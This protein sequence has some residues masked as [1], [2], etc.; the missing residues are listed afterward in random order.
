VSH[1]AG[2]TWEAPLISDRAFRGHARTN[3]V[4]PPGNGDFHEPG[5][6]WLEP[7][8]TM[9]LMNSWRSYDQ[10]VLTS[11]DLVRFT[12]LVPRPVLRHS[13]TQNAVL[14]LHGRYVVYRRMKRR[15]KDPATLALL[16]PRVTP[17][18]REIGLAVG[19]APR[20]V[21]GAPAF[22]AG[23]RAA[24]TIL[25]YDSLDG[26]QDDLYNPATNIYGDMV[27][28]FPS[29]FAHTRG[30]MRG[31]L[32]ARIAVSE[33]GVKF[34]YPGRSR[35]PWLPNVPSE[36]SI[37]VT[38]SSIHPVDASMALAP[39]PVVV[40]GDPL[41]RVIAI[42]Y[43][44]GAKEH[45]ELTGGVKRAFLREDGFVAIVAPPQAQ[46]AKSEQQRGQVAALVSITSRA[47]GV[48]AD[49][50]S[51]LEFLIN[52]DS[53]PAAAASPVLSSSC[54]VVELVDAETLNPLPGF[55]RDEAVPIRPGGGSRVK[56][57]WRHATSTSNSNGAA[58]P[59]QIRGDK[60]RVR[61]HLDAGIRF[62]ALRVI[63][64]KPSKPP[65]IDKEVVID[66]NGRESTVVGVGVVSDDNL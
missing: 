65:Q 41:A 47:I 28:M 3:I 34:R 61:I 60:V 32:E 49:A 29:L 50:A 23:F 19:A 53:D 44:A 33:D 46:T 52:I 36:R 11:R 22:K 21:R 31:T 15:D 45:S 6:A 40:P 42:L 24:E 12:P 10:W 13:D 30:A 56:V 27:L 16:G 26:P 2:V 64:E 25:G 39:R 54:A 18:W 17:R 35:A 5:S 58:V 43:A 1:D 38:P 66:D 7:D 55:T 59:P 14:W 20:G 37:Y 9:M 57:E 8:G 48:P 51:M 62:Y 63:G 4:W